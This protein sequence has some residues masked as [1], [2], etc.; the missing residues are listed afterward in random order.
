MTGKRRRPPP[1]SPPAAKDPPSPPPTNDGKT[2]PPATPTP[3]SGKRSILPSYPGAA[4]HADVLIPQVR[5]LAH[6][7]FQQRNAPGVIEV[8]QL[9]AL[10]AKQILRPQ[11][12]TV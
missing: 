11:K 6:K 8:D 4:S 2:P 12:I 7:L 10:R 5:L 3:P 9:H 1:P